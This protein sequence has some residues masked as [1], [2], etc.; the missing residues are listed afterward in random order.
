MAWLGRS[1]KRGVAG[2]R[3]ENSQKNLACKPHPEEK[4]TTCS[5]GEGGRR[6]SAREKMLSSLRREQLRFLYKSQPP[7]LPETQTLPRNS[8]AT[9][10]GSRTHP[11]RTATAS[12]AKARYTARKTMMRKR[13]NLKRTGAQRTMHADCEK[14]QPTHKG[15]PRATAV[16]APPM[17][18]GM[19]RATRDAHNVARASRRPSKR[20]A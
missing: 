20:C 6:K 3:V 16:T 18:C 11:P 7:R 5:F 2:A 1:G 12:K 4:N 17:Q 13:P 15:K 9:C 10:M 8:C 19:W 14:K